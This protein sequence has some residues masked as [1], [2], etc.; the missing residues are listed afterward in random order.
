MSAKASLALI[1]L[2]CIIAAIAPYTAFGILTPVALVV[3]VVSVY[4]LVETLEKEM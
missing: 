1:A 2:C 4:H 3:A